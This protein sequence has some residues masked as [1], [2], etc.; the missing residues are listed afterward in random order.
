MAGQ[1]PALNLTD[2][3]CK[4]ET[5]IAVVEGARI[6]ASCE[7]E[8]VERVMHISVT[9]LAAP[10]IGTLRAFSIGF[11]GNAVIGASAQSGWVSTVSQ[12]ADASVDWTLEKDQAD[13]FG[14]PSRARVGGF[15]VRLKPGWRRSRSASA[16]WESSSTAIT[17]T[18]DC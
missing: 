5:L 4:D 18:H 10:F 16:Q 12:D 14:V 2:G 17:T 3:Q 8:G 1:T 6:N 9:N 7:T 13:A 11:C 15:I